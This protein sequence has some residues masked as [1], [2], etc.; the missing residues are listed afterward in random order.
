MPK[1]VVKNFINIREAEI[2]MDKTLVVFIGATASGKSVLAKLLYFFHELIRDFRQYIKQINTYPPENLKPVPQDLSTVFRTQIAHKFREF[3]GSV[4]ELIPTTE[5]NDAIK[6]F[7]ITYH[8]SA[9]SAIKLTL[10]DEKTLNIE[11]PAV[12]DEVETL[13]YALQEKLKGLDKK[14]LL[15]DTTDVDP[16]PKT[17]APSEDNEQ[18]SKTNERFFFILK[19]AIGISDITEKLAGTYRDSLFIPADRN[20]AVNY[21]DALKRIF[22]GGIKSDLQTRAATR[23]RANL[24]L[25]A[26][27]LEKNEEFLDTFSTK[28][29]HNIFDEKAEAESDSIDKPM[30]EFLLKEISRILD[31]EHGVISEISESRLFLHPTGENA[32][33]LEKASTGQQNIIRILQDMFMNILYNEVIFRVIEEPEAHLHPIAQKHL[34]Y[35]I[36]LMRNHIDSQIVMTTHSPYLLAILKNLLTAGQLSEKGPEAAAEME[37]F[38]PKLCWLN[39]DDVEVYH[40]KKGRSHAIVQPE[41]ETILENPLADLLAEFY[42]KV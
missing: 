28:N 4:S 33:F 14:Q 40:L 6:P 15:S 3:F 11:L 26:R 1:L 38:T 22:Y 25:V 39:P 29:F 19:M 2:N 13:C 5:D 21:P 24:H 41:S 37:A 42:S 18:I 36:A 32:A 31:T 30:M 9:E 8:Y 35:I 16:P 7:E 20:I 17:E 23:P 12:M 10:D 27:F 34:M